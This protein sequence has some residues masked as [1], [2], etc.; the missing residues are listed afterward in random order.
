MIYDNELHRKWAE[1]A[2]LAIIWIPFCVCIF[3]TWYFMH[4]A[5]HKERLLALEKNLPPTEITKTSTRQGKLTLLTIGIVI[6]GLSIGLGIIPI[7]NA[8]G[9]N[10][11]L[12]PLCV[13]G[14]GGGIGLV[15]ANRL[16]QK[17]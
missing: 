9:I 5:K 15:I 6:I 14:L 11:G 3:L 13:L 17:G 16:Q 2:Q 7:L 8:I 12:M 1:I 4:K 10:D